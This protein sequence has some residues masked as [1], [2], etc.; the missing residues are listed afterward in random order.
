MTSSEP[1]LFYMKNTTKPGQ[2][3]TQDLLKKAF[4]KYFK[5]RKNYNTI[6]YLG[7]RERYSS[8]D[9][10]Y[11]YFQKVFFVIPNPEIH[12]IRCAGLHLGFYLTSWGMLRNSFLLNWGIEKYEE[13]AKELHALKKEDNVDQYKKIKYFITENIEKD[14][15]KIPTNTLISKIMLG[16]YANIPALDNFFKK[17]VNHYLNKK[18]NTKNEAETVLVIINEIF[19]Q[20]ID[21]ETIEG[22]I[23]ELQKKCFL[24]KGLSKEKILDGIFFQLGKDLP[25]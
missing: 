18:I 20:V 21:E 11:N 14:S 19:Q 23:E 6:N 9:L 13:L 25:K 12:D 15:K 7:N 17:A 8:W 4:N 24:A 2:A 22:I 10:C 1:N 3:I 5:Y 16:V